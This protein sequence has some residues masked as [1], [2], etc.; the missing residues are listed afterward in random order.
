MSSGNNLKKSAWEWGKATLVAV[1]PAGLALWV[2]TFLES[3]FHN[4]LEQQK[5]VEH[6]SEKLNDRHNEYSKCMR[7][8]VRWN[9]KYGKDAGS[10]FANAMAEVEDDETPDKT[11][12]SK[13]TKETRR[14]AEEINRCRS[15]TKDFWRLAFSYLKH[16]DVDIRNDYR[17][18]HTRFVSTVQPIDKLPGYEDEPKTVYEFPY[19]K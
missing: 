19:A 10:T 12:K 4:S 8:I 11:A 2:N 14:Q 6:L 15:L 3:R 16:V 5:I 1:V 7:E 9:N 13:F 17:S 18:R